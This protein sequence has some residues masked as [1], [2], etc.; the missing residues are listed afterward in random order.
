MPSRFALLRFPLT[1]FSRLTEEPPEKLRQNLERARYPFRLLRYWWAASALAREA[2]RLGR[3]LVVVDLGCER[4]WLR[5]FT[6]KTAV[7]RWIGLDW[8]PRAE[9]KAVYDVVLHANFDGPL[10]LGD[11]CADAVVSLHV[12][13]HLPRPGVTLGEAARLLRPG[14]IFLGCTPT[15]PGPLARLRERYFRRS[16][17]EGRIT[18]GG[19]ITVLSPGRWRRLVG[20]FGLEPE[21]VTGS[22]AVRWSGA[23]L[24]N[25]R[26]W[27][28]LN[29]LWAA[30]FPSLGSECCLQARR[31]EPVTW[32]ATRILRREHPWRWRLA[33]I[34]AAAV[35]ALL[36]GLALRT[37]T[38]RHREA[39]VRWLNAHQK[40]ADIFVF[41]SGTP[42]LTGVQRS[43]VIATATPAEL[44]TALMQHPHAHVLVSLATARTFLGQYPADHWRVDSRLEIDHEDFL[45]LRAN[46]EGTPLEEYLLGAS[47]APTLDSS[48]EL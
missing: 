10:P 44:E 28:R 13:E 14:G 22:H 23:W 7:A 12:F 34:G 24:E 37:E 5:H 40:G 42:G 46:Q 41:T 27:V 1:P 9:T 21:F 26:I 16:L 4:G 39:F 17:S 38:D 19:H 11:A 47:D 36:S 35:L 2:E 45:M 20:E 31:P 6:P 18:P 43:D 33:G 8:N 30:L 29:Q 3:P 32:Q 15:M 48:D 25:S